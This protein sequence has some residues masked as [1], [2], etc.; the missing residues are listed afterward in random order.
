M[1]SSEAVMIPLSR[2]QNDAGP[3]C[4]RQP[5]TRYTVN[6]AGNKHQLRD[7]RSALI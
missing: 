4:G 2:S 7:A 1:D 5:F 6:T 3:G